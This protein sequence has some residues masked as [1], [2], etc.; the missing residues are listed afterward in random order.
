MASAA[1]KN[2][3]ICVGTP[4]EIAD[5]SR[6]RLADAL[7]R[8]GS[9]DREAFREV[10]VLTSARLFGICLLIC[11]E[12]SAAE[13]ILRVVYLEVWRQAGAWE[14][15]RGSPITW[16]ASIARNQAIDWRRKQ[17][18]GWVEL[19][20][21]APGTS[22]A[23]LRAEATVLSTE[24]SRHMQRCLSS[25]DPRARDAIGAA[26]FHG[27]SYAELAERSG[28][29]LVAIKDLVRRGLA[30]VDAPIDIPEYASVAAV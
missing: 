7:V 10:Y 15:G 13:D 29:P 16:L 2:R 3:A 24:L 1:L 5:K 9:Q 4:D 21:D 30:H 22:N 27:A 18:T 17:Q 6:M 20:E 8:A 25:I 28:I 26:Y 23:S 14:P 19:I 12:R 11:E